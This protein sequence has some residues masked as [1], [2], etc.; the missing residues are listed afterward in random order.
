MDASVA[1]RETASI[2]LERIALNPSWLRHEATQARKRHWEL[3]ALQG[4][5]LQDA[6]KRVFSHASASLDKGEEESDEE[7]FAD[8]AETSAVPVAQLLPDLQNLAMI[9]QASAMATRIA[10]D[11]RATIDPE[12][13]RLATQTAGSL[14][15]IIP[16]ATNTVA[17][18]T[19]RVEEEPSVPIPL[20]QLYA[21]LEK[22][23]RLE[24]LLQS[25]FFQRKEIDDKSEYTPG[26]FALRHSCTEANV[27]QRLTTWSKMHGYSAETKPEGRWLIRDKNIAQKFDTWMRI[28]PRSTRSK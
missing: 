15:G 20:S 28:N 3:V 13:A 6:L 14:N 1:M 17:Y 11:H 21:L 4:E 7:G 24:E 23:K 2:P 27:R 26:Y 22:A 8:Q 19:Q 10:G 25:P 18:Y 9:V 5:M 16:A 12:A